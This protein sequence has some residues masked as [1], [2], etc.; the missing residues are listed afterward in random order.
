MVQIL[1]FKSLQL[2][3]VNKSLT[4]LMRLFI[5]VS[6]QI[7]TIV[8]LIKPKMIFCL[9]NSIALSCLI[10]NYQYIIIFLKRL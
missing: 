7:L 4:I 6:F 10:Y 3:N 9:P 2:R 8:L 5:L 1:N